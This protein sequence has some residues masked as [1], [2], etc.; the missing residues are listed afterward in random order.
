MLTTLENFIDDFFQATTVDAIK[1]TLE[2]IRQLVARGE[3][4]Q[5]LKLADTVMKHED[6]FLS[7]PNWQDSRKG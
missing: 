1:E 5:A 4:Y 3:Y 7:Q 6:R 2:L